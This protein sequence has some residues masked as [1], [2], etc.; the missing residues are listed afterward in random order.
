M[1][2]LCNLLVLVASF[3][4]AACSSI[5]VTADYDPETDFRSLGTF[6]WVPED[7][8]AEVDPR[9]G[10]SLVSDRVTAAIERTLQA[11]GYQQV[12]LSADFLVG[13]SI[14]VRTGVESAPSSSARFHYGYYGRYGGI[15]YSTGTELRE[16]D[17]GELVVDFVDPTSN[18]LIW[19]GTAK[20][21]LTSDQSPE[22]SK[23]TIDEAVTRL[24]D[25][26]PP[27]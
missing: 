23:A 24:L 6:S 3:A 7:P 25:Q 26:F 8:D 10:N 2:T 4:L 18:K 19:R 22:K 13:F 21:R 27:S 9:A 15:G 14:S 17:E 1:K 12:D 5:S 16:F 20:T 11:R